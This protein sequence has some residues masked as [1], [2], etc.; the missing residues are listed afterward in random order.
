MKLERRNFLRAAATGI[1]LGCANP[2]GSLGQ[3][4]GG[5]V[6]GELQAG[7]GTLRLQGE[8]KSGLLKVEAQD[9]I[10]R[11]DRSLVI[12]GKLDSA[13]VYS[14]MFSYQKDLTAF[15]L[16]HDGD[17]STTMTLSNSED[18]KIGRLVVWNDNE[19][20]QIFRID[21]NKVFDKDD[22]KGLVDVDGKTPDLVG[23]RKPPSFTWLELESVFGSDPALLAFSRGRRSTHHPREEDKLLE[24]ICKFLSMIPG[25]LLSLSW[26]GR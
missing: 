12:R 16:F 25:S 8:L 15:A 4:S 26:L 22:L 14:A 13:E 9:F 7:S 24:W 18:A 23:K 6:A 3:V 11:A 19:I 20:P 5:K 17:H 21:K 1:A 10:D 2:G